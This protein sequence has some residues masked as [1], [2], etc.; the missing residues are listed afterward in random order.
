MGRLAPGSGTPRQRQE[1]R[2]SAAK[3]IGTNRPLHVQTAQP[4]SDEVTEPVDFVVE[5]VF[6]IRLRGTVI[7]GHL[8]SGV[9]RVGDSLEVVRPDGGSV[10]AKVRGVELIRYPHPEQIGLRLEDGAD[11]FLEAGSVVRSVGGGKAEAEAAGVS[12]LFRP[13]G[14]RELQRIEES[15]FRRFPPRLQHQPIFYPVLNEQYARQ[16]ARDWNATKPE[17]GYRGYVTRFAVRADFVAE[18]EVRTVGGR[19]HQELWIPAERLDELNEAMV[20]PIEVIAEY[21][22]APDRDVVEIPR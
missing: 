4:D 12:V 13:V 3:A 11:P 2:S 18:F 14:P 5:E 16:I 22:G 21:H 10:V 7:V 20:G 6:H 9:I 17:T 15:E 19:I 8:R 1:A